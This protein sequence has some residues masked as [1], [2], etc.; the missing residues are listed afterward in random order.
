MPPADWR[1]WVLSAVMRAGIAVVFA[2]T[3]TLEA[4]FGDLAL[5]ISCLAGAALV[6]SVIGW[7]WWSRREPVRRDLLTDLLTLVALIPS[8]EVTATI[9]IADARFGGRVPNA[10]AGLGAALAM[11][12]I[13]I[14]LS[15]TLPPLFTSDPSIAVLPGALA[16]AAGIGGATY[17]TTVN[18]WQG[19]SAAWLASA[20]ATLLY[21]IG[22]ARLRN[23]IAM[24]AFVLFSLALV[25]LA[26]ASD[27]VPNVSPDA[28]LVAFIALVA[29]ALLLLAT[30]IPS[31]RS[32]P[33][34][35]H[36]AENAPPES[37]N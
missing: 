37:F 20:T 8:V 3:P 13:L 26:A 5:V 7:I 35:S 33:L 2:L 10:L 14:L 11:F 24:L 17:F 16:I 32:A 21:A 6:C 4:R 34:T 28:S 23:L 18:F 9:Q 22:P 25:Y 31:R 12:M 30:A 29:V 1:S 19:I 36:P 15:R 27:N